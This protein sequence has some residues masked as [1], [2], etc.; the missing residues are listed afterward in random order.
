M[1]LSAIIMAAILSFTIFSSSTTVMAHR[2]SSLQNEMRLMMRY[3]KEELIAATKGEISD[4]A[5]HSALTA[6]PANETRVLFSFDGGGDSF[7]IAMIRP[8]G[9]V[10]RVIDFIELPNLEVNFEPKG[11]TNN[12]LIVTLTYNDPDDPRLF[13]ELQDEIL[14]P[15]IREFEVIPGAPWLLPRPVNPFT[16]PPGGGDSLIITTPNPLR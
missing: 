7:G 14:M 3:I 9:S 8:G 2:S 12:I 15:N 10:V 6:G 13:F 4:G 1:V 5:G 16:A 11:G